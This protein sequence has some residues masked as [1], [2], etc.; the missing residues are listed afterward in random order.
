[1]S[2]AFDVA[3]IGGGSA[4]VAAAL[5]AAGE[6]ARTLLLEASDRLG[7]NASLAF[8]HTICGL[9][10]AADGEAP[11]RFVQCGLP[12]RLAAGL[13]TAGAAGLPERAGRVHYLPLD[14]A[15][16]GRFLAERCAGQA[17]LQCH[18]GVA[19]ERLASDGSQVSLRWAGGEASARLVVDASGDAAAAHRLGADRVLPHGDELQFPSYIVQLEG[20][21]AAALEGFARLRLSTALAK[22]VRDGA[23]PSGCDSV[24]VRAGPRPGVAFLT[25]GVPKLAGRVYQPLDPAYAAELLANARAA[26]EAVVAHLRATRPPFAHSRVAAWPERV[27]LRETARGRARIELSRDDVL[28]ARR[29]PDE[30]VL[31]T[32]PIELWRD[33]RRARFEHPKGACG[34]PLGSLQSSSHSRLALA[35]R[36]MGGSHEAL[37]ALRVIGTALATGEA[38]GLACALAADAGSD[39]LAVEPAAVRDRI[40]QAG[41]RQA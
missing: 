19:L 32:W 20:V 39:L 6:G 31:S 36:C 12:R 30:V 3:V 5:A 8:V 18:L 28:A 11:A 34:V 17:G 15:G 25:L 37:G 14:P 26:A 21:D 24:V 7:G 2:A 33:Y 13:Q 23:L 29:R 1:M 38:A 22:A 41:E 16:Y 4:G 40:V 27:G 10:E 35:G 9:F